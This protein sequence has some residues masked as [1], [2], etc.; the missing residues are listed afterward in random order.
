MHAQLALKVLG[1]HLHVVPLYVV[2]NTTNE[3][4]ALLNAGQRAEKRNRMLTYAN[5]EKGESHNEIRTR[6]HCFAV[7]RSPLQAMLSCALATQPPGQRENSS[8][9]FPGRILSILRCA[10]ACVMVTPAGL[11]SCWKGGTTKNIP[12]SVGV[13]LK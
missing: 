12:V 5:V 11:V 8:N 6:A 9:V 7:G 1:L 4:Q 2:R 13:L 10:S 3:L